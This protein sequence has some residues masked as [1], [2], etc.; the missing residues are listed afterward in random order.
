M[1]GDHL[2]QLSSLPIPTASRRAQRSKSPTWNKDVPVLEEQ[3][4]LLCLVSFQTL[5]PSQ[6]GADWPLSAHAMGLHEGRGGH[7]VFECGWAR[8]NHLIQEFGGHESLGACHSTVSLGFP[9]LS[10]FL[11]TFDWERDMY[12]F[13]QAYGRHETQCH[14]SKNSLVPGI[15][16]GGGAVNGDFESWLHHS[17]AEW[18][19][20]M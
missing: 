3:L 6:D 10:H 4:M 15:V 11:L 5:F 12:Y 18:L 13:H 20:V 14:L 7:N 8:Y 2:L 1:Q 19:W 16:T 9:R 17:L